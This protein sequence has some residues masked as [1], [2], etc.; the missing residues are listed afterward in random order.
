MVQTG[1]AAELSVVKYDATGTATPV[2]GATVAGPG[3]SVITDA[4]GK[5]TATFPADGVVRLQASKDGPRPV[6]DP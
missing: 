3:V 4:A 2:A 1:Q 6:R 5:A